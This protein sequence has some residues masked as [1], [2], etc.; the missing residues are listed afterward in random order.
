MKKENLVKQEDVSI[1]QKQVFAILIRAEK[2]IEQLL[3]KGVMPYTVLVPAYAERIRT[4][5]MLWSLW[6]KATL[7]NVD[8]AELVKQVEKQIDEWE[9]Q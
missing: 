2:D 9:K 4:V 7:D 6:M 8:P 3:P 1:I 5:S